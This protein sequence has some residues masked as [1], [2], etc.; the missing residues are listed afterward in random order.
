MNLVANKIEQCTQTKERPVDYLCLGLINYPEI[1]SEVQDAKGNQPS[2]KMHHLIR[3]TFE[4]PIIPLH[5]T[6]LLFS[7]FLSD[8][9]WMSRKGLNMDNH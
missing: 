8:P 1:E 3:V 9:S 6:S 2:N 7:G 4:S 5:L